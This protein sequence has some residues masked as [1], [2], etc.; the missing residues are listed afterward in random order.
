MKY[1]SVF[2]C[3][4]LVYWGTYLLTFAYER[5]GLQLEGAVWSALMD[6]QPTKTGYTVVWSLR[7]LLNAL[8]LATCWMRLPGVRRWLAVH[9]DED[10]LHQLLCSFTVVLLLYAFTMTRVR[11]NWGALLWAFSTLLIVLLYRQKNKRTAPSVPATHDL[12]RHLVP[13]EE[14]QARG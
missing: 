1:S 3:A 10:F 2:Y 14:D 5:T 9:I 12:Q 4:L 8:V 6:N 11:W 13:L 7:C